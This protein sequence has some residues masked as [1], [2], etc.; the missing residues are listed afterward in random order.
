MNRALIAVLRGLSFVIGYAYDTVQAVLRWLAF[1][2]PHFVTEDLAV[3]RR[4]DG[5]YDIVCSME[6]VDDDEEFDGIVSM[7]CL[8]WLWWGISV[9]FGEQNVE[10]KPWPAVR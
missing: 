7:T 10:V 9:Q 2:V 4:P 1:V 8:A 6:D 3:S 5:G